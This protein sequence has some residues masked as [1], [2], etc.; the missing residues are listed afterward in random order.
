MTAARPEAADV[1]DHMWAAYV[2]DLGP[3]NNID[4][5]RLPVPTPRDGEVLVQVESVSVNPVDTFVR[6]GSFPTPTPFP[7]II[8]R[9]LVGTVVRDAAGFSRGQRVWC[10]S[11]G[12]QG[13]QGA[14]SQYA[15]VPA[16]RLYALPDSIDVDTAVAVVHPGAT[17]HLAL[18]HYGRLRADETVF[19]GGGAGHVG[20]AAI[21]IARRAGACVITSA[22]ADDL[23]YCRLLGAEVALDYRSDDFAGQLREAAG[24]G[25]GEG[26]DVHLDT[27][28]HPDLD[29]ATSV[30]AWRG[31][32]IVI[33]GMGTRPELPAGPFYTND[34]AIRG[35]VISNA[36]ADELADAATG[37][38]SMLET[39]VLAPRSIETLS[40]D[41]AQRAHQRLEDGQ[42]RGIRMVIKP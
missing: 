7:F 22:S 2:R 17:A 26:V 23:A 30:L 12:H 32:I 35:F 6:S 14:T 8:G 3:A 21:T 25:A 34:A 11:M 38:S 40:L 41:D 10:N 36:T 27:S 19:I 15:A 5:G 1:P 13:R 42:A 31:R 20:S 16:G 29:V 18:H 4:I 39:G 9:D 28:G 37:I 24:Q 33:A